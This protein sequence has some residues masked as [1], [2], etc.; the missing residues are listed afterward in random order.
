MMNSF[1]MV[2]LMF[3][4]VPAARVMA[5]VTEMPDTDSDSDSDSDSEQVQAINQLPPI[6][7]L[8]KPDPSS[9]PTNVLA[10]IVDSYN[11]QSQSAIRGLELPSPEPSTQLV[12]PSTGLSDQTDQSTV[13]LSQLPKPAA[14]QFSIIETKPLNERIVLPAQFPHARLM[15]HE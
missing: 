4:V 11:Q 7:L 13:P 2:I 15:F 3:L 10:N 14:R 1:G 12:Q 6:Q 8:E 9:D 5:E